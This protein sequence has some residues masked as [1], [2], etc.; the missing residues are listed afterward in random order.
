MQPRQSQK[1]QSEETLL[2]KSIAPMLKSM[3]ELFSPD[4][5]KGKP[6]S[7]QVRV[8]A[9]ILAAYIYNSPMGIM[10]NEMLSLQDLAKIL[11]NFKQEDFNKLYGVID[12][13]KKEVK[14]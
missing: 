1:K 6:E 13:M 14:Q 2:I 3:F 11:Y 10:F 4:L 8:Q 12:Q 7:E 9:N 5:L